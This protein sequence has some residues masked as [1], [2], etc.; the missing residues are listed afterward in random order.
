MKRALSAL[1]AVTAALL[2][3]AGAALA[4]EPGG[5]PGGHVLPNPLAEKQDALRQTGLGMLLNG[6]LPKGTKVGK[7][8]KGQYV[9]LAQEGEGRIFAIL[10]EFG[11][12]VYPGRG[13]FNGP[14]HGEMAPPD[15]SVDNTTIFFNSYE[16]QHYY[17]LYFDRNPAAKSVAN[18]YAE[19]SSGR[20]SFSGNVTDWVKVAY[21]EARYGSNYCGGTVC[22][23]VWVLLKDAANQWVLDQLASGQS[24][25][26]IKA[27]L[28]TFDVE[29]RY[30]YN[31]DGNFNEP[32]GYIDHFQLLH[33]GADEAVGGGAQGTDAIWSHRWYAYQGGIGAEGPPTARPLAASRS[34][35]RS[36]SRPATGSATT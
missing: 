35:P 34:V 3:S 36:D 22:Q 11:N 5:K 31:G 29:D 16:P 33:A 8:A 14:L 30:D 10:A 1:V 23:S 17:D 24:M 26:Q 7:V 19:Q 12:Q 9:K 27:Y 15:R 2:V 20:F 13:S 28:A 4:A 6:D 25:A 32:D 21:N 18:W